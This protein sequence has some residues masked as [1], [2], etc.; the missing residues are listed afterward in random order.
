MSDQEFFD[1]LLGLDDD[2]DYEYPSDEWEDDDIEEDD[3]E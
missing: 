3:A 1:Y 2:E